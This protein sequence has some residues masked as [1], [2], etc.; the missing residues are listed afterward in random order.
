MT[1]EPTHT[2]SKERM[3]P[4]LMV[5]SK[6]A[7]QLSQTA[8]KVQWPLRFDFSYVQPVT[9]RHRRKT[10]K[11]V[12]LQQSS[13]HGNTTIRVPPTI[14]YCLVSAA[15]VLHFAFSYVQP[16]T[17]HYKRRTVLESSLQSVHSPRKIQTIPV[18]KRTVGKPCITLPRMDTF[19]CKQKEMGHKGGQR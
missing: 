16:V 5:S 1:G 6:R 2:A 7:S 8:S 11:E 19:G 9:Q 13:H 12:P 3:A 10:V 14:N 4:E 18:Y 15:A 17:Q